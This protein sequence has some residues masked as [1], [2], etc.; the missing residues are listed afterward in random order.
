M[1]GKS[2]EK[3][4]PAPEEFQIPKPKPRGCWREHRFPRPGTEPEGVRLRKTEGAGILGRTQDLSKGLM[5]T[6]EQW[7]KVWGN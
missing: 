7:R 4:L 1:E 5:G 3:H 6:I 2:R